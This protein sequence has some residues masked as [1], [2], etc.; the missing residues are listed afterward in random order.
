VTAL[1]VTFVLVFGRVGAL[2]AILPVFS[3]TG[4][5]KWATAF[6][7]LAVAAL[8][9]ANLPPAASPDGVLALAVALASEV[10]LG[11]AL[12]IGVA[13]TFAA[14][15]LG[16]ELMSAQMSFSFSTMFDPFTHTTESVLGT[17]ASWLAGLCFVGMGLHDRCLEIVARSFQVVP[18]GQASI[19]QGSAGAAIAA[20]GQCLVLGVQLAGP[21]VAMVFLVH[22]FVAILAKLAPKMQAFFSVGMTATGAVGLAMLGVSLPWLLAAHGG[23]VQAAVDALGRGVGGP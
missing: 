23:A 15:S 9:T 12:G 5:P 3:M 8:V 1:P 22:L 10:G 21:V 2:L 17:F 20:V 18:P 7:G 16:A 19:P 4:V 11:L 14:L 13:A 6:L